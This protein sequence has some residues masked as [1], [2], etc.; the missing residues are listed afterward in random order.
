MI[1]VILYLLAITAIALIAKDALKLPVPMTI[2]PLAAAASYLS[3]HNLVDVD[4]E[5]FDQLLLALLPLLITTDVLAL[6]FSDV[7]KNAFSLF[8]V[9]V[10][11]VVLSVFVGAYVGSMFLDESIPFLY[12]ILLF[13]MITATDPVAVV[14]VMSSNKL[15]HKLSFLAEGESLANDAVVLVLFGICV[16][17]VSSGTGDVAV[18][19]TS[20]AVQSLMVIVGALIIGLACGFVGLFLLKTTDNKIAETSIL[21][22]VAYFAF[23]MAEVFHWS[24]IL[25]II[26]SVMTANT[27]I[28]RRIEKDETEIESDLDALEAPGA[29]GFKFTVIES[30]EGAVKDKANHEAIKEFVGFL[31]IVGTSL[32][33]VSMASMLHWNVLLNH[34]PEIL[35]T[36]AIATAARMIMMMKFAFVSNKTD[37][38]QNIN[39]RWWSVLSLAGVKGGLSILMLHMLPDLP[40]PTHQELFEAVVI[41]NILLS[42]FIYPTLMMAIISLFK[43]RFAAELEA[44]HH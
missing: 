21:L 15:P 13:A 37:R 11:S 27:V 20:L 39:V 14:N 16:G 8:Y 22:L 43:D 30:L 34:I 26:V 1:E 7:K 41:G 17:L 23:E 35:I 10:V 29:T 25:A 5:G 3:G 32:L 12:V 33:F 42:T 38:M 24:G 19:T 2:L 9:A 31:A 40:N 44:E 6:K 28:S 4:G 36:F 18:D